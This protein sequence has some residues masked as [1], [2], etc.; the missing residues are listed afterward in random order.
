[1]KLGGVGEGGVLC[2][3]KID[4]QKKPKSFKTEGEKGQNLHF[5]ANT[6]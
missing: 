4:K 3:Q 2:S 5:F 6:F 1:M